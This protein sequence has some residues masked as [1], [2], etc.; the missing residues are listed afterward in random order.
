MRTDEERSAFTR[1]LEVEGAHVRINSLRIAIDDA[2]DALNEAWTKCPTDDLK[3][4]VTSL[5]HARTADDIANGKDWRR[6][7]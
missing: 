2:V 5:Q 7:A 1:M 3:A 4:I 6:P